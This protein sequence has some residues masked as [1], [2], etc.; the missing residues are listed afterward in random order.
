MTFP[1]HLQKRIPVQKIQDIFT[2]IPSKQKNSSYSFTKTKN[3]RYI[4][5][6]YSFKTKYSGYTFTKVV[7]ITKVVSNSKFWLQYNKK[8]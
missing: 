8:S 3:S 4:F 2:K 6:Q 5:S 1:I 7:S